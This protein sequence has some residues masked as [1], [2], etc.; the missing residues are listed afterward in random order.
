M[1]EYIIMNRRALLFPIY[2]GTY[3]RPAALGRVWTPSS[4]V[5]KPLAYRDWTI[6]M[7]K[8][9]S[10]CIDYLET[11]DDID[12]DKIA[13]Y[14]MSWG[15]LLGPIMLAVEDRLYT[16]IFVVGGI[17]PVEMPRSFDTA[18][19]AQRVKVPVLMVNGREDALA[20]LKTVQIPMYEL[21][22]TPDEHKEHKLYPGGHGV[23]GLFY[24]QIQKDVLDWLDRYLGPAE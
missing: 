8:D 4:A 6:Q 9:L 23:F 16:G 10:R 24:K 21:L 15:A 1:T 20:R 17:P 5:E 12:S 19:Y 18:L 3:E 2:K 11:R 7:A 14:G 13:Y 22:G